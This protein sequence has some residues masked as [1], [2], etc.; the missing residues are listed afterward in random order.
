MASA[1]HPTTCLRPL[2]D[3]LRERSFDRFAFD[4]EKLRAVHKG[5]CGGTVLAHQDLASR[6]RFIDLVCRFC[7]HILADRPWTLLHDNSVANR[8]SAD[9]RTTIYDRDFEAYLAIRFDRRA[10]FLEELGKISSDRAKETTTR[11]DNRDA[12]IFNERTD[13]G[14]YGPK[15]RL[16]ASLEGW[17]KEWAATRDLKSGSR[18]H[19][20]RKLVRNAR[21]WRP[22]Q[23]SIDIAPRVGNVGIGNQD[24][25]TDTSPAE[26]TSRSKGG[27][28]NVG[29]MYFR[30][31]N[32]NSAF[33]G[34]KCDMIETT[35][36]KQSE[37]PDQRIPVDDVL[38]GTVESETNPL[39]QRCP[40]DTLRYFHFP[41]NNMAWVEDA[42]AR[43]YREEKRPHDDGMAVEDMQKC[44]KLLRREFWRGQ[45][46]GG[47]PSPVH[48][49][50]MRP[51]CSLIP[52][53]T[54]QD[55]P[56][57]AAKD[58][59]LFMPYLHWEY[60]R[61]QKRIQREISDANEEHELQSPEGE[62]AR[63]TKKPLASD[64][65][66]DDTHATNVTDFVSPN[67]RASKDMIAAAAV[68]N[69]INYRG[70]ENSDEHRVSTDDQAPKE[71]KP[72]SRAW[73]LGKLL[74]TVAQIER[75]MKFTTAFAQDTETLRKYL[76]HDP[77]LHIRRT[78]D[79]FY[80]HT[81]ED[82]N[83][84]DRD[85][86]VYR[87]TEAVEDGGKRIIMVD[88]LWLWILDNNTI[89]TAFPKR[90]GKNKAD[91]SGVHR[92]IRMRLKGAQRDG[93]W[94]I[95]HL[96]LIIIDQCSRVFFDRTKSRDNSPEMLDLFGSA[97]GNVTERTCQS[98]LNFWQHIH[99]ISHHPVTETST[100]RWERFL[101]IN[102]E[103][104]LLQE[105]Q[106]IAEELMILLRVYGQQI[107]VVKEFRRHLASLKEDETR[108]KW[109]GEASIPKSNP[110][111]ATNP[112]DT[113][114]PSGPA[115]RPS[116]I[117]IA[118]IQ[119]LDRLLSWHLDTSMSPFSDDSDGTTGAPRTVVP[120]QEADVVLELIESRRSELQELED[121]AARTCTQLE[122]LLSLKQQQ[123]S[124][125]EAKA[126]K[127]R[128]DESVKQG[129]SIIAFTVVTI[130]FLPLGFLAGFFGMNNSVS[131]GNGWMT[132]TEQIGYMFGTSAIVVVIATSLAFS[133]TTRRALRIAMLPLDLAAEYTGI[134]EVWRKGAFNK[135]LNYLN[136]ELRKR[137]H[138]H[139]KK[140]TEKG[141]AD[142]PSKKDGSA[143]KIANGQAANG[144]ATGSRTDHGSVLPTGA[145]GKMRLRGLSHLNPKKWRT[146]GQGGGHGSGTV[147]V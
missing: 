111:D 36:P 130:F 110:T 50:H 121:A 66:G 63:A 67:H 76:H 46:H 96:A 93:V 73:I 22:N 115:N 64:P 47:S 49:R 41:A 81:L 31:P 5:R 94:S 135:L 85:Q 38:S 1:P 30:R 106:D 15:K 19:R 62:A 98:Y 117:E 86:V 141:E 65:L 123:A 139:Q 108:T 2:V 23:A 119:K 40:D 13:F 105:A 18:T 42:M 78:L 138:E 43:Y 144:T 39:S 97:I 45:V 61:F 134:A 37:F 25:T 52:R 17:K 116:M 35:D 79:Q 101:R 104:K 145:S 114:N 69:R 118:V 72:K 137:I 26:G 91:Y 8:S 33:F 71:K 146:L 75:E 55:E 74:L 44:E 80:F 58:V 56:T 16:L 109:R 92:S 27:G 77:P 140:S 87:G 113:T 4:L 129:R 6:A 107:S 57:T 3:D 82:T 12:R 68:S 89:I 59:A 28:Y 147:E 122:G 88:Q 142:A 53:P 34:A 84:R 21:N 83:D 124:I 133:P 29:V 103:G 24:T 60:Y 20:A 132:L 131:T 51:R 143:G 102:P 70:L 125:L 136:K 48:A 90:W 10:K 112:N 11:S 9:D 120:T 54:G 95:H 32:S 7:S 127:I 14:S 99:N 128:A 100:E 126:A